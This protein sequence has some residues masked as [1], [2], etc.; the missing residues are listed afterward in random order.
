MSKI[1]GDEDTIKRAREAKPGDSTVI[2]N[3]DAIKEIP[4][5]YEVKIIEVK[6]DP[7]N[8]EKFFTNVGTKY[9]PK[10]YPHIEFMY[11]IAE[12][13]GVSGGEAITETLYEDVEI[14]EMNMTTTGQIIKKK[15]GYM[16]KKSAYVLEEDGTT[17]PSGERISIENAWE[18]CVKAWHKEEKITEGYSP[19]IVK[20]GEYEYYNK[21]Y[22]GK[23][24]FII[25]GKYKNAVPLKY[26]TKW[27]RK[28]HFD[29]ELAKS[30]GKADSKAKS[31][32][33][34]EVVG[35]QT[36]FL[37]EDLAEGR[38]IVSRVRRS[39][40]ILQ[41]ESAARLSAL[42]NGT[43]EQKEHTMLF[44]PS[45]GTIEMVED[46]EPEIEIVTPTNRE[47]LI[48]ALEYYLN[49]ETVELNETDTGTVNTMLKWL[50]DTLDAESNEAF[51]NKAMG[52]LK[53]IESGIPEFA[54]F[55]HGLS[56]DN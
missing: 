31:K 54:R 52:N 42:S 34:R 11:K 46:T 38:I 16:V 18:E 19:A 41:A 39:R 43:Q 36:G 22:T 10:Y 5:Q 28:C 17:R 35:L 2:V 14:D 49:E 44:G 8:L 7:S 15:V 32:A 25:N 20:D 48:K 24:Y 45:G 56:V 6:F 3:W 51:W 33:I 21:K 30:L 55:E 26:D 23:H 53:K 37:P 1:Y 9:D 13:R 29:D 4:D 50:N 27:K 47:K 12:A 40:G